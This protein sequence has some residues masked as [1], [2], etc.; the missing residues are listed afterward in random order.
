VI[1]GGQRASEVEA[2]RKLLDRTIP[3][4]LWADLKAEG[5]IREDAPTG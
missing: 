4:T 1:P 5:L 2:N 3:P